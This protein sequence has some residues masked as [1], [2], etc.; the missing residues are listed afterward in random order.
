M[1][2]TIWKDYQKDFYKRNRPLPRKKAFSIGRALW[3]ISRQKRI[4]FIQI[5]EKTGLIEGSILRM[6]A[7]HKLTSSPER[8]KMLADALGVTLVEFFRAAR[9]EFFGNFFITKTRMPSDKE[10][11][12]YARHGLFLQKQSILKYPDHNT[13]DFRVIVY[14]PPVESLDDFFTATFLLGPGKM[15]KG[16]LPGAAAIYLAVMNGTV[17]IESESGN[18]KA[19][20]VAGQAA[21]FNGGVKHSIV[22]LSGERE[23]EILI[24]FAPTLLLADAPQKRTSTILSHGN[25]DVPSLVEQTRKWLAPNPDNPIPLSELALLAG[26]EARDLDPLSKGKL[27]NFPLEKIERL[28]ELLHIPMENLFRGLPFNPELDIEITPGTERGAYDYRARFGT[29]F[30]PWI[31]MG[32][33]ARKLFFGHAMLD[34]QS[35]QQNNRSELSPRDKMWEG[36][37]PGYILAKV[38]NGKLGVQT[39]DR[40][41]YS[42]IDREDTVYLD[43]S[44]GFSFRNFSAAEPSNFFLVTNP[45]LF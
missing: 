26:L 7:S 3:A 11:G 5:A 37:N 6:S 39:G 32:S 27:R 34:T 43:M 10:T 23:A 24:S 21:T 13:P 4:K 22:N 41:L 45:S 25:L 20:L 8:V 19:E 40:H 42:D 14:T 17:L 28:A 15:F 38:L 9:E 31:K 16:L 29:T 36:K 44:L 35:L 18:E 1:Y 2:H 12:E 33:E 30:Y